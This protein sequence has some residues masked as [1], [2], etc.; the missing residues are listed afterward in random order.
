MAMTT[1]TSTSTLRTKPKLPLIYKKPLVPER[2]GLF[3]EL[4]PHFEQDAF[5]HCQEA[6]AMLDF[7]RYGKYKSQ[8]RTRRACQQAL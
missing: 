2:K 1:M 3:C 8:P 5:Y 6:I 7:S 4:M